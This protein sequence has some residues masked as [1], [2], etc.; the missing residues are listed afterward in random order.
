MICQVPSAAAS[1][2][3]RCEKR[4]CPRASTGAAVDEPGAAIRAWNQR[5]AP[6][7]PVG[8]PVT[9]LIGFTTKS[10]LRGEMVS[11]VLD[12]AGALSSAQVDFSGWPV[13]WMVKP[14]DV[15]C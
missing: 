15:G 14:R 10:L 5:V 11:L 4:N 12:S 13:R 9:H 8:T 7:S 1:Y 3:I 2:Y 6:K